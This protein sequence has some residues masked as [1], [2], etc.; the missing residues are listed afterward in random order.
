V[1]VVLAVITNQVTPLKDQLP[2][3]IAIRVLVVDTEVCKME[4]KLFLMEVMVALEVEGQEQLM[5]LVRVVLEQQGKDM[6][7][8]L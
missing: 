6:M 8:V 3:L 7:E 1:R 4:R 5:M 2:F